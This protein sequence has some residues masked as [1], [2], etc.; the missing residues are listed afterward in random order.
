MGIFK[1]V[2]DI[3]VL[4]DGNILYSS[5]LYDIEPFYLDDDTQITDINDIFTW[6]FRRFYNSINDFDDKYIFEITL[7]MIDTYYNVNHNIYIKSY[8][9]N[10]FIQNYGNFFSVY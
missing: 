9:H 1:E 10:N 8:N 2:T 4:K 5:N 3:K 7:S 6:N